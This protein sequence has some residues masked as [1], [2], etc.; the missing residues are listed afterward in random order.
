[1]SK[2][3]STKGQSSSGATTQV[4]DATSSSN[5]YS[6]LKL[7]VTEVDNDAVNSAFGFAESLADRLIT[8]SAEIISGGRQFTADTVAGAVEGARA[9]SAQASPA[10]EKQQ[11][12]ML[13]AMAAVAVFALWRR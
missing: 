11:Q 2:V 6:A 5:N 9:L 3:F 13:L 12:L 8:N 1:M 4:G 10:M 7:N